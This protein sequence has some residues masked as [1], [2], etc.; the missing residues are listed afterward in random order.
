MIASDRPTVVLIPGMGNTALLWS[1]QVDALAADYDVIVP[2]YE[3]AESIDEMSKL[4]LAQVP[5]GSFSLVGFS[6]GAYIALHLVR[7][8]APRVDRLALISASPF[9][10]TDEVIRGRERLIAQAEQDYDGVLEGIGKFIVCPDGPRACEAMEAV[11]TMGRALGVDEFCRQQRVATQR[12]D[13]CGQ[14]ASIEAPTLVLCGAEDRV[15]PVS[16]NRYLAGHI[17]G[18]SLQVLE[19]TGHLLP[20][21]RP[22]EVTRL[23]GEWLQRGDCK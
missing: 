19:N 1:A 2:G 13:A 6:L 21:E 5:A 10:D 14:L 3:G 22:R 18:A 4:V 9:A 16:G 23:L 8:H 17:P 15:T 11:A 7:C 20:L 12:P